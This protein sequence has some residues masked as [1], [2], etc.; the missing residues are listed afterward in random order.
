MGNLVSNPEV[1]QI[2][3]ALNLVRDC[4][5]DINKLAEVVLR[6]EKGRGIRQSEIHAL[7]NWFVDDCLKKGEKRIIITAP[8]GHGKSEQVAVL[9]PLQFIGQNRN[10][11]IK[12]ISNV[13]GLAEKRIQSLKKYIES[14][15]YK[16]VYKNIEPDIKMWGTDKIRVLRESAAGDPTIEAFGVFTTA[17]GSRCDVL[18]LD[19]VCDFENSFISQAKREK[20]YQTITQKWINRLEPNGVLIV[21]R[22]IWHDADAIELLLKSGKYQ[23]LK[24][25]VSENKKYLECWINNKKINN[26][27]LWFNTP[28]E[29]KWTKQTLQEREIEIGTPQYNRAFRQ[30]AF[31]V[32]ELFFDTFES[33]LVPVNPANIECEYKM[34]GVDISSPKRPG[35]IISIVGITTQGKKVLVD[36]V[37]LKNPNQLPR[38]LL[39][40][41]MKHRLEMIYVE[42]NG[43]QSIIEEQLHQ[44][45]RKSGKIVELPVRGF[46]TGRNKFD[47]VM[48]LPGLSTQFSNKQWIIPQPKHKPDCQCFHCHA[49][50]EFKYY[51]FYDTNDIVM[52]TWFA[53]KALTIGQKIRVR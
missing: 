33:C 16:T 31:S 41:Y 17:E 39:K 2:Q 42:N 44:V 29:T 40:M 48:G 45:E 26:L 13:P 25:A 9:R 43:V 24:I 51:P 22:T 38:A 5:Q 36:G 12:I 6:D 7:I 10:I 4:R 53:E 14:L 52:A 23:H 34:A 46:L 37:R 20:V 50:R 18:I 1:I 3:T 49:I 30:I 27:P 15:S 32:D 11:R 28:F 21:I 19:D 35:T 47:P 8:V